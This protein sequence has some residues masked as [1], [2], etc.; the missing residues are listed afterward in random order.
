MEHAPRRAIVTGAESG[1][2]RAI[3]V[4][5]A[6]A[7]MDVGITWHADEAGARETA[8]EVRAH[9][10]RAEWAYL[11]AGDPRA[12]EVVDDLAARL[13]GIDI[14]VNNAGMVDSAP[15]LELTD[16]NWD[17]TLAVDLS[18]AFRCIQ[19]AA[20]HMVTAGKGGRL[21][22]VTSVNEHLPRVGFA[23][24]NAAKHGLG[25]LIK[26]AALELG[27]HG[28]TANTVAPGEIATPMTG[29]TDV[30]PRTTERPGIPLRRSG[31]AR[32]VAAAVAFLA[33][34][35]ASYI[36]GASLVVDGGM[37]LMG[38]QGG[39]DLGHDDWRSP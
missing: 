39:S 19:R 36:T 33:S 13:G 22:A 12:A 27:V 5:L 37:L 35:K 21:I 6:A 14:F 8:E 26:S 16:E 3:A 17:R 7:G 11:D 29:M 23:A 32:E 15:F 34:E 24:Y 38:P 9:E 2:G 30:D 4:E 1:I 31:D 10:S 28:I 18:G 20:R 25:G